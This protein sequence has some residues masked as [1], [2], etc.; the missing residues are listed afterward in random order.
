[1]DSS[2][3]TV[4]ELY[5]AKTEISQK[6][7]KDGKDI[8]DT[9]DN[10]CLI[11]PDKDNPG[12]GLWIAYSLETYGVGHAESPLEAYFCLMF[13]LADGLLTRAEENAF[14]AILGPRTKQS[15]F[16]KLVDAIPLDYGKQLLA[17]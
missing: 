9:I 16:D 14:E 17:I 2:D 1:M 12:K 5:F 15:Y 7:S 4:A 8:T 11:F 10:N 3:T 6:Y 13:K